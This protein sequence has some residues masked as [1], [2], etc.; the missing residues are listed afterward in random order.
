MTGDSID[1]VPESSSTA[2]RGGVSVALCT[3]NGAAY[4]REQLDSIAAQSRQPVELVV[5]D[6]GS[7]DGTLNVLSE[8]ASTASF[9]VRI[10]RNERNLGSTKNFEKAIL[11]CRGEFIA[12]CDQDDWWV[13]HKIETALRALSDSSVGGVFSDGAVM[14]ESSVLTGDTLWGENRFGNAEGGFGMG[15]Q[16]GAI[17]TLLRNN[18]VTG[19]ALI[20]RASLREILT[21]FPEQWVHDGW[22]AWML[23]LH[24]RLLAIAEP[25]I[26]YRVHTAQ[27]VGVPGRSVTARLERS[28]QTGA[29]DYKDI[30]QQFAVLSQYAEIHP[31]VCPPELC[32]RIGA[33][34]RLLQL[35]AELP[36]NRIT[37]LMSIFRE[38]YSYQLYAQ[39]WLSMV[40]DA[41][42]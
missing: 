39:G 32:Q 4:L 24:S 5:C 13:P 35:R 30:E 20:F 37:R 1:F 40:K 9:P 26:R 19:A 23:V 34:R 42:A 41:L 12:L 36:Q 6:D 31:E 18:V 16:E 25:L 29:R 11:L 17:A 3:F 15:T 28:R 22:M 2:R 21:P 7:S 27:Q 8:F 33:K 10:Y 14:D 38:A